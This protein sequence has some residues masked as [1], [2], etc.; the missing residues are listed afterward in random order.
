MDERKVMG[1]LVEQIYLKMLIRPN[2]S[3]G[4]WFAD[5][6]DATNLLECLIDRNKPIPTIWWIN[7]KLYRFFR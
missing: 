4:L 6:K 2:K 1:K 7:P 3:G 5:K